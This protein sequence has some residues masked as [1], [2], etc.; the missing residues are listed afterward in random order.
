MQTKNDESMA[1]WAIDLKYTDK[2]ANVH[3]EFGY[4]VGIYED[5]YS[6]LLRVNEQKFGIFLDY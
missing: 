2:I 1:H 4:E 3:Y 5:T 6:H